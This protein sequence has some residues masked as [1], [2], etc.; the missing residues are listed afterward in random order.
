MGVAYH[1]LVSADLLALDFSHTTSCLKVNLG[2]LRLRACY[3]A[4]RHTVRCC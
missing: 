3:D 2:Q 4:N 1:E